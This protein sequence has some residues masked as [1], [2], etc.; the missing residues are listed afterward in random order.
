V[1]FLFVHVAMVVLTGFATR[2]REMIT[3]LAAVSEERT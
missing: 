3:G 1:L 2:M